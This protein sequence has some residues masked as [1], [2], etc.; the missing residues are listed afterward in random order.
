M[1]QPSSTSCVTACNCCH[2]V[3]DYE[4]INRCVLPACSLM[5]GRHVE[6]VT[7]L[8]DVAGLRMK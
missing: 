5:A 4:R 3:Q 1:H 8:I 6:Q 2:L 7:T